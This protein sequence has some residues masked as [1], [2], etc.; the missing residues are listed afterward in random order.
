MIRRPAILIVENDRAIREG[1]AL[2][3]H[4]FGCDAI[5][6][7]LGSGE[8]ALVLMTELDQL[9]GLYTDIELNDGVSGWK[10]GSRDSTWSG[11]T[12]VSSMPRALTRNRLGFA[13]MKYFF[14]SRSRGK[15][16]G[17]RFN[18]HEESVG[19]SQARGRVSGAGE[20]LGLKGGPQ[21]DQLL[22][23][24]KN[25]DQMA[26][27]RDRLARRHPEISLD[28]KPSDKN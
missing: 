19:I 2:T 4:Q 14:A 7:E 28:D 21:R 9:D 10:I 11:L 24:A 20:R 17:R 27:D 8:E 22:E 1:V 13:H 23:M 6:V 16:S 26:E 5:L 25:W 18:S 15:R 3:L 12:N